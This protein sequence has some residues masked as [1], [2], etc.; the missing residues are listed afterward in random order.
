VGDYITI[1]DCCS[2]GKEDGIIDITISGGTE[3]PNRN[4]P[5]KKFCS[6]YIPEPELL[7]TT[8]P[9][10]RKNNIRKC[11]KG[12]NVRRIQQKLLEEGFNIGRT[13]DDSKFGILTYKAVKEYQRKYDLRIDGIV[14]PETWNHMFGDVDDVKGKEEIETVITGNTEEII[15]IIDKEIEKLSDKECI[16]IL[17]DTSRDIK[18]FPG[19]YLEGKWPKTEEDETRL[20]TIKYCFNMYT[21]GARIPVHTRRIKRTFRNNNIYDL[22]GKGNI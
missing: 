3:D 16:T 15:K 9:Y 11:H 21:P 19:K 20:E 5:K 2:I 12:E 4:I 17:K 7:P 14:G 1:E 18:G 13:K 10:N 6:R 8:L 22:R